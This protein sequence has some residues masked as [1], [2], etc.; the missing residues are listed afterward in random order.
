MIDTQFQFSLKNKMI[1]KNRKKRIIFILL[2]L[3]IMFLT[4]FFLYGSS[5]RNNLLNISSLITH[6]LTNFDTRFTG[7]DKV[8]LLTEE[9]AKSNLVRDNEAST[10][11]DL[12]KDEK[13]NKEAGRKNDGA[14]NSKIDKSE[15]GGKRSTRIK[16]S[17]LS[18]RRK[19]EVLDVKQGKAEI[20]KPVDWKV[21]IKGK[22]L[23]VKNLEK[24]IPEDALEIALTYL[25]KDNYLLEYTT[26]KVV[27]KEES[28]AEPG[29]Y[30]K[31]ILIKSLFSGNYK[32][33]HVK[34]K[35]KEFN[36]SK[37]AIKIYMIE[38]PVGLYF[39][40]IGGSTQFKQ[41]KDIENEKKDT[42]NNIGRKDI[43]K[44][45][46][47][48]VRILDSDKNGLFDTVEW[49]IPQ[50][51][52]KEKKEFEIQIK[53]QKE[54][55]IRKEEQ[56][57][58]NNI[59]IRENIPPVLIKEI[60]DLKIFNN[61]TISINLSEFF[62]DPDNDRLEFF[63]SNVPNISA[64]IRGNFVFITPE[65]SFVGSTIV[66]FYASD[67]INITESNKVKIFVLNASE[68]LEK[69]FTE[70]PGNVTIKLISNTEQC[71]GYCEAIVEIYIP[72]LIKSQKI[73]NRKIGGGTRKLKHWLNRRLQS[74]QS[75]RNSLSAN[76]SAMNY[77]SASFSSVNSGNYS[78]KENNEKS[79]DAHIV[80]REL[81]LKKRSAKEN[82]RFIEKK[83]KE[84]KKFGLEM[85]SKY[86]LN[87]EH[88]SI[89]FLKTEESY[90]LENFKIE[91]FENGSWHDLEKENLSLKPGINRIRISGN[92]RVKVGENN[93]DWK[94]AINIS[95]AG[96]Y[97]EPEW[98]WWN[99]S[100]SYRKPIYF[101]ETNGTERNNTPVYV[102]FYH[103]GNARSDCAD[104][105]ITTNWSGSEV[106][107]PS[108]TNA[109]SVNVGGIL[110]NS[111]YAGVWFLANISANANNENH[112][113]VY[114][115]N[116]KASAPSYSNEMVVTYGT[117]NNLVTI[118][119][120]EFKA[121][122]SDGG[123]VE[124]L[125]H[126]ESTVDDV[127]NGIGRME[128]PSTGDNIFKESITG[129]SAKT[130]ING[131]IIK[132]FSFHNPSYTGSFNNWT[133]YKRTDYFELES[134]YSLHKYS[135][136]N[137]AMKPENAASCGDY[138]GASGCT[139]YVSWTNIIHE[140]YIGAWKNNDGAYYMYLLYNVSPTDYGKSRWS[141]YSGEVRPLTGLQY[142]SAWYEY[143]NNTVKFW[144]GYV[145]TDGSPN[146]GEFIDALDPIQNEF[147]NPITYHVGSLE[148][149]PTH[150]T[151]ILNSTSG[152]NLTSDNLTCY[153]QSTYDPN[154]DN[155]TN[156]YHWYKNNKSL[157]VLLMPFDTNVSG[158]TSGA[159]KDYSGYGNNGTLSNGN[160]GTPP[161]WT[162][163]CRIGGCYNFD[164]TYNSGHYIEV[165]DDPSLRISGNITLEAWVKIDNVDTNE[166]GII[167]KPDY[168]LIYDG[169]SGQV[170]RLELRGLTDIQVYGTTVPSENTWY[171][172][173]GT[174]NGTH[175]CIYVN[176]VQ[177]KCDP[178]SGNINTGT[179]NLRIGNH[180]NEYY[181]NGSIDEVRIYN[182]SLTPQ[183]I[184]Q[185]YLDTKDGHTN[186]ATIVSQETNPGDEWI[187][188][189]TPNDAHDD[190]IPKN[191]SMLK[192]TANILSCQELDTPNTE[193]L[194]QTDISNSN[195]G[196]CFNVTAHNITLNCQNHVVEG[197]SSIETNYGVYAESVNNITIKNCEF[198][199]W[200]VGVVFNHT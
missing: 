100:W 152:N 78:D 184:Y 137:H 94:L 155:V 74:L 165:P 37:N 76:K 199:G 122:L 40:S 116:P 96:I 129:L 159:V 110:C 99:S 179:S 164:G 186:N 75:L 35:I 61:E 158:T 111:T 166:Q 145:D 80:I 128:I 132:R 87:T 68:S 143:F 34:T 24:I 8:N 49:N 29:R 103:G 9:S 180:Y 183:Q 52:N 84:A 147:L 106:E 42:E 83:R 23:E 173:A 160:V 171:H 190:G 73:N 30:V 54:D 118:D 114:Y 156:I 67:G 157:T 177:E 45:K 55:G 112:Y 188:E 13:E 71:L 38:K 167:S 191:S 127:T 58:S 200:R 104:I 4:A 172:V 63:S 189:V 146:H 28:M 79:Y 50:I 93:I 153:N 150:S 66:I 69:N 182:F 18:L 170:F 196:V 131:T 47:F 62:I 151:P 115:G 16:H 77:M 130:L 154:G 1:L 107:E 109:T 86:L 81:N 140:G 44:D 119:K 21:K 176:G 136:T 123:I 139:T 162:S 51:K 117:G 194:L 27:K 48:K 192:I 163:N 178:S 33:V 197:N 65:H 2:I 14:S 89:W 133:F 95:E 60:P 31:R 134:T 193:Y 85:D 26:P 135:I 105:R 39:Q 41:I 91:K 17:K 113:F 82:T 22:K 161:T 15:S 120:P 3:G 25:D 141:V 11:R 187:C 88:L 185:R 168:N 98:A 148:G 7:Q 97:I 121:V 181:F 149:P 19:F 126:G 72:K 90:G 46:T 32:N 10:I 5:M 144:Y 12:N 43:T 101:N 195:A 175:L 56:R 108:D 169:N 64:E 124:N 36:V 53:I 57:E 102:E 138:K 6:T 198:R 70:E 125:Y 174:Y 92:K 59:T 142:N 20:D